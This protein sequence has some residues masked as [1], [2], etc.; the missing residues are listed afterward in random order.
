LRLDPIFF[1][2]FFTAPSD[3][4]VFFTSYRLRRQ[5]GDGVVDVSELFDRNGD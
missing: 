2:P 4:P 1:A 3:L 5:T